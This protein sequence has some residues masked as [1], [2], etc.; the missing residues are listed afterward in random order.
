M[1]TLGIRR[2]VE[3]LEKKASPDRARGFT[4]EELCR[5]IWR[6]DKRRFIVLAQGEHQNL[7]YLIPQFEGEDAARIKTY[8][9][10]RAYGAPAAGYLRQSRE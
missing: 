10:F 7:R 2:R 6:N 8:R 5:S 4:M 3:K 1:N 9:A